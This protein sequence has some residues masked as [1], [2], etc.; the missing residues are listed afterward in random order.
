MSQR[1]T[2]KSN[3]KLPVPSP[4]TAKRSEHRP[5]KHE[6][7][8][9]F[10]AYFRQSCLLEYTPSLLAAQKPWTPNSTGLKPKAVNPIRLE[11]LQSPNACI[12]CMPWLRQEEENEDEAV[13]H[14]SPGVGVFQLERFRIE[15]WAQ[16]EFHSSNFAYRVRF[17][18]RPYIPKPCS[19]RTSRNSAPSWPL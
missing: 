14:G 8:E 11:P 5:K 15:A 10:C 9:S 16:T 7:H 12:P 4:V 19:L 17:L 3:V 1:A 2:W 18:K 6:H 13:C